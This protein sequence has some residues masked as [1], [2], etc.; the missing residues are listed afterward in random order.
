MG[1]LKKNICYWLAAAATIIW[2]ITFVST[3][4]L[5]GHL[6]PTEILF[7]RIIIAYLIFFAM[8]P[9]RIKFGTLREEC[10]FAMAGVLGISLYFMCENFALLYGTASNV[11]LLVSTA[12]MLTGV[13]AHFCTKNEKMTKTFAIGSLFCLMGA[14]LIVFNGHFILKLNPLGDLISL[15]AA[16]S[17]AFYSIIIR[18]I[19][20][21]L[22]LIVITR[23]TFFYALLSMLPLTLTQLIQW[24]PDALF[25]WEVWAN[26]LFLGAFASAF[27]TWAW[28]K[29]IW[30]LGAVRANNLIYLTP[31]LVM[32]NAAIILHERITVFAVAG[33]LLTLM[34]VYISQRDKK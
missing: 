28:S 16:L 7:Y 6:S 27:C 1:S 3:K 17:F 8:Y 22:S 10:V 5:L 4:L 29:V 15:A 33:G 11:A 30:A 19:N 24:R 32:I 31:P 14:F 23:K 18:N 9:R 20:R 13:V 2:S 25:R 34:G 21:D 26:L 12:P